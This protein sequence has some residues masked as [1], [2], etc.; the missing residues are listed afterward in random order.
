MMEQT[1][2]RMTLWRSLWPL[3]IRSTTAFLN[4]P[5]ESVLARFVACC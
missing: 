2:S 4:Y 1:S 5:T 3:H